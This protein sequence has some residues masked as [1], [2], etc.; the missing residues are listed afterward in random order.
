MM[1][2]LILMD[3]TLRDGSNIVGKAFRQNLRR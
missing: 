3:C 2:D 1:K